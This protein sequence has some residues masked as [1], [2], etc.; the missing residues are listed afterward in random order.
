MVKSNLQQFGITFNQTFTA[1]VKPMA[2]RVLMAIAAFY[3][4]NIDQMDQKIVS[5]YE[6][7][8]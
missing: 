4:L 5:L 6:L 2:F 7:I 3:D 8:D 1:L